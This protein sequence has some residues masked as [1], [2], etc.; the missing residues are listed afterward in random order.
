MTHEQRLKALVEAGKAL[1]ETCGNFETIRKDKEKGGLL[2]AMK[3]LIA[4][5]DADMKALANARE[6]LALAAEIV[7]A[8]GAAVFDALPHI[9][10]MENNHGREFRAGEA[11][12]D[13]QALLAKWQGDQ[14]AK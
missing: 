5:E 12:R 13:L 6:T 10:Q 9:A 14:D 3:A 7:E 11:L 4:A 8:A 1:Q 2:E